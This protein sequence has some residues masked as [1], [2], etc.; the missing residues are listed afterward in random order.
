MGTP[1]D[2]LDFPSTHMMN[3]GSLFDD[4]RSIKW[5]LACESARQMR[6]HHVVRNDGSRFEVACAW[7]RDVDCTFRCTAAISTK[8]VT[9]P[10]IDADDA[11]SES[12]DHRED[13]ILAESDASDSDSATDVVLVDH[14]MEGVEEALRLVMAQVSE[15]DRERLQLWEIRHLCTR[16]SC[17]S[18]PPTKKGQK[19]SPFD[20]SMFI[21]DC[22]DQVRGHGDE[23]TGR[24]IPYEIAMV[25]LQVGVRN[26]R[27]CWRHHQDVH[28]FEVGACR[29]SDRPSP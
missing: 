25:Y 23:Y 28:E 1:T 4:V 17:H 9:D 21:S 13:S 24:I 22:L 16:H 29:N 10:A 2:I 27:Y 7:P 26:S 5:L 6:M 12:D 3:T 14:D 8:T 11:E 19:G 18:A 15:A 20:P